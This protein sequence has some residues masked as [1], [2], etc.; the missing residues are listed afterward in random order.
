MYA[1]F[2][3]LFDSIISAVLALIGKGTTATEG[4]ECPNLLRRGGRRITEY[5]RGRMQSG[6]AGQRSKPDTDRE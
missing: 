1:I 3:S 6:S 4:T 5:I 2:R